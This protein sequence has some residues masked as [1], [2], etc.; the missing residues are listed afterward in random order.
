MWRA[1]A[2]L[3][4]AMVLLNVALNMSY[5]FAAALFVLSTVAVFFWMYGRVC[6]AQADYRQEQL[7]YAAYEWA[8]AHDRLPTVH[9]YVDAETGET[10]SVEE[11]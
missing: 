7:D 11:K 8:A 6:E 2:A 3:L 1:W 10:L 5:E 4:G 9:I